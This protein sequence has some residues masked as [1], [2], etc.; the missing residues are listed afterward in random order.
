[1]TLTRGT[2]VIP[3]PKRSRVLEDGDRILCFGK[4]ELMRE[5]VP[6]KTRKKR[7]KEVEELPELPVA[8]TVAENVEPDSSS[9]EVN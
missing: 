8:Q 2:K 3:N 1:M 4:L 9:N 7:K 6:F 5:L